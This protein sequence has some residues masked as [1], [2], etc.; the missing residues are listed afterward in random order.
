MA[1]SP[2][3]INDTLWERISPLLPP[4]PSRPQGGRPRRSDRLVL[5]GILH[6]LRTGIP[7]EDLPQ[8]LGFGSGMT[9]WR[10]LRQWQQAEAWPAMQRMLAEHLGSA[11]QIEWERAY[12]PGVTPSAHEDSAEQQRTEH[13]RRL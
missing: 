7:W 11:D 13:A 6:V 4:Q 5:N 9:C 1:E 3:P 8:D 12:S 2:E 10:R